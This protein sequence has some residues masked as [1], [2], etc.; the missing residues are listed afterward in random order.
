MTGVLN[1]DYFALGQNCRACSELCED[2]GDGTWI[3]QDG[4]PCKPCSAI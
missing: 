1:C 4:F 3:D 2:Q